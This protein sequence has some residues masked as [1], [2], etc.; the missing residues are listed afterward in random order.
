MN[1]VVDRCDRPSCYTT[2][3]IHIVPK[4]HRGKGLIRYK[5]QQQ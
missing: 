5:V 2:S 1:V 4:P 3:L